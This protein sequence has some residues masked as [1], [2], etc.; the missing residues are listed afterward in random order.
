MGDLIGVG[1][2]QE[3]AVV[4]DTP[5]LAARLQAVAQPGQVVIADLTRRL[6]GYYFELDDLG[7]LTLKG[8]DPPVGGF[9]VLCERASRP[10]PKIGTQVS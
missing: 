10:I 2:A 8:I 9:A 1:T 4:G 7:P 3:E 5:N 6:A